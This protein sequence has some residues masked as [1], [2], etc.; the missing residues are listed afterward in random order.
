MSSEKNDD[1]PA[2]ESLPAGRAHA[3][4][5][6]V[7][8]AMRA[9]RHKR[10]VEMFTAEA[11]SAGFRLGSLE[12][13]T[14]V[15]TQLGQFGFSEDELREFAARHGYDDL[16][17]RFFQAAVRRPSLPGRLE[18]G[19]LKPEGDWLGVFIRGDDALSYA[20]RLRSLF[21]ALE[22]RAS[23]GD[24]AQEEISAWA[25]LQSLVELLESCRGQP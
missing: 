25:K 2:V 15:A 9:R 24:V 14:S 18:T 8:D 4:G 13:V 22:A 17:P 20:R 6:E 5:E 7:S 1:S 3:I 12:F 23:S 16:D 19:V 21:A 10:Y 11:L